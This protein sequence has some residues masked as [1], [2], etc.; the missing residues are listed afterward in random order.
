VIQ[1]R[2]A[3]RQKKV[4][5]RHEAFDAFIERYGATAGNATLRL[6]FRA[7]AEIAKP[8]KIRIGPRFDQK[9]LDL[10]ANGAR[11]RSSIVCLLECPIASAS[12]AVQP[13]QR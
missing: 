10:M 5:A 9:N 12:Q 8:T 11:I 6:A 1:G 4:G 2:V 3:G 7:L 13:M